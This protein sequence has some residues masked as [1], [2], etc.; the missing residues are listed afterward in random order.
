MIPPRI[1]VQ[2]RDHWPADMPVTVNVRIGVN[3]IPGLESRIHATPKLPEAETDTHVLRRNAI[4]RRSYSLTLP[5]LPPGEHTVDVEFSCDRRADAAGDWQNVYRGTHDLSFTIDPPDEE[6]ISAVSGEEYDAIMRTVFTQPLHQ[7]SSGSLPIRVALDASQTATDLFADVAV[8]VRIEVL[9]NR[10]LARILDIWWL[11]GQGQPGTAV[12]TSWEVPWWD[13][14]ILLPPTTPDD[15]W[16]LHVRGL[17]AL[18][19]RVTEAEKYW[20][21]EFTVP[22]VVRRRNGAAPSLGWVSPETVAAAGSRDEP[23][24]AETPVEADGSG[25]ESPAETESERAGTG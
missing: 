16:E 4:Q 9:R 3:R 11:G 22:V 5:P 15:V 25:T 10:E 21:G 12:R 24:P 19:L 20:D 14:E 8:G 2:T 6:T 7:W 17:P 23:A 1:R 13:D 18:A